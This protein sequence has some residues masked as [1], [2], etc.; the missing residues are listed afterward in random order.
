MK[1]HRHLHLRPL[2]E[3]VALTRDSEFDC[4]ACSRHVAELADLPQSPSA[5][6]SREL[7]LTR[8]H[9]AICQQCHDDFQMLQRAVAGIR[10]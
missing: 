9:L 2:L 1:L 3:A 6:L 7:D 8:H 10:E 4:A 5:P